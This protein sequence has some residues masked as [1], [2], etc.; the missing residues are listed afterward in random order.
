MDKREFYRQLMEAYTVD[1]ER[2]KRNAKRKSR[3]VKSKALAIRNW[4]VAAAA[5]GAVTAAAVAVVSLS[6][7][8][9]MD[10]SGGYDI[11]DGGLEN[12]RARVDAAEAQYAAFAL[13][14]NVEERSELYVSFRKPLTQNEIHMVLSVIEDYNDITV[15][16]FYLA[17]GTYYRKNSSFDDS[18]SFSGAKVSAPAPMVEE[19]RM[20]KEIT[21]VEYPQNDITDDNFKPFDSLPADI[22]TTSEAISANISVSIPEPVTQPEV[23]TAETEPPT[24]TTETTVPPETSETTDISDTESEPVTSAPEETTLPEE[25]TPDETEEPATET[26]TETEPIEPVFESVSV[27]LAG[28]KTINFINESC[29][30]AT[31]SDS[32]RLFSCDK[33][34]IKL[35]TTYYVS[36]AKISC[37]SYD[38]S[39]LFIIARDGDNRTRLY[40]ADGDT[41]L[42]S[43]VDV[44]Y[45]TSG[46]AELSSVSCSGDGKIVLMKAVSLDKTIVYYGE[47]TD[48]TISLANKEYGSPVSVLAYSDGVVYTAVTDSKDNSVRI[49]SIAAADNTETE[50][51]SYTGTLKYTR[52]PDLNMA[53][54]T[55]TNDT[56]EINVIL[57]SGQLITV[58][59]SSAVFSGK[60]N[61]LVLSGEV[62]YVVADGM[63]TEISEEEA[64]P[65]FEPISGMVEYEISENGEAAVVIRVN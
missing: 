33:G 61:D 16:L 10:P 56:E 25:S 57:S 42:L 62:Y 28:I 4:T 24:E 48:G 64:K 39:K 53:L 18:L 20:L 19:I 41:S 11:S 7:V 46:G 23:T 65:Y 43:E 29:F 37:S 30:V 2:V 27:P 50:L 36:S 31:T 52:S 59:S 47:R 17:D 12:A 34:E 54:L 15:E 63:L 8:P 3:N 9:H 60:R 38:G 6:S 1:T 32:I 21:L 5:C 40:Y 51:A 45:I 14:E 49:F 44:S 35:E 26:E 22:T 55:V 58:E 13:N